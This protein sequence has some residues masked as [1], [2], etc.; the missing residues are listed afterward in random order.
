MLSIR[1]IQ[2]K[3]HKRFADLE[4]KYHYMGETRPGGDTMRLVV[5]EDG[6]WVALLSWGSAS[7]SLKHRDSYIGWTASLRACRQK[8]V[9]QNRRFTILFKR[10]ARPN[11]ASQVLGLCLRELPDLWFDKFG[12]KPLLAETF[13]N[14]EVSE[15]TCYKASG[16]T[17][18]G[19]TKG[20]SRSRRTSTYYV[21]NKTP[22]T[23]WVKPLHKNA[24][25]LLCSLDLP[26]EYIKGTGSDNYGVLALKQPQVASLYD[27]LRKVKDPRASNSK[28][29]IASILSLFVL[30]VMAGNKD[31]LSIV[32]YSEKLKNSQREMLNLPLY[33]RSNKK[34]TYRVI[35]SYS[36]FY[37]LLKQLDPNNFAEV[38]CAWIR[39]H[40]GTLPAQLA[41]DGKFIQNTVGIVSV[42]DTS[43]GVPIAMATASQKK[44]EKKKSE[45]KVARKLINKTDLSN[46]LV[47][48]DAL[49]TQQETVR[50]IT[51]SGGESLSQV[52]NN[53]KT[54]LKNCKRF[55]KDK[56]S[57]IFFQN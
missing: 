26:E 40:N 37:N 46:A 16:W 35:P 5:E 20:F 41:I 22:K 12:Y 56:D 28:F 45:M 39:Q 7:Y 30:G 55:A 3:E 25:G 43:S 8:L 57:A 14:R 1:E 51:M 50:E 38:L 53:Q 19:R 34:N 47:S 24:C 10:G 54:I 13:S 6:A 11:L 32:K 23:L 21:D 48:T 44:G 36:A 18:L 4:G 33:D 49:H 2:K 52:K 31:L 17:E 42:V 15:G 29:P 27:A 9:V